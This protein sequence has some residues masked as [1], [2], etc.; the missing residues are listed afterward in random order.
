MAI[1]Y[2]DASQDG[3]KALYLANAE[4]SDL[5]LLDRIVAGL[6][7]VW[8]PGLSVGTAW[9]PDGTRLAYLNL[10]GPKGHRELQVWTV[11]VN[12]SDPSLVAS[13][14]LRVDG[15]GPVWSPD[16]SQ[17]AFLTEREGG[18][19]PGLVVRDQLVVNADGTGEPTEIDELMYLSWA[20]GW[21][22]CFCYG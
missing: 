22:F 11:S 2:F 8:H 5:R 3:S 17:I 20:G 13:R 7:P 14:L 15:G 4:G 21:Y 10:S 1:T 16:G 9:S 19:Q 6:W 18:I 12:G